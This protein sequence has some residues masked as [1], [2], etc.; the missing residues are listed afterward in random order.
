LNNITTIADHVLLPHQADWMA[1]PAVSRLWRANVDSALSG[2]EDRVSVRQ[3]A[4]LK[5]SYQV[6]P[7]DHVERARF[8]VRAK[9][10]LKAGKM[11][12][13]YWG[14]GE[15]LSEEATTDQASIFLSRSN[16]RIEAGKYIFIQPSVP[17]EYDTWD[18]CLVDRVSGAQIDLADGL[19]HD[20]AAG[21]RVW[22]ILFGKPIT[23]Q[24]EVR[25][26][27]RAIYQ[28][29]I[30]FDGRQINAMTYD[31]FESYDLGEIIDPLDGGTGWDGP[32]LMG[33]AA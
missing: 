31:N 8:D 15:Q 1:T 6:H 4:W 3:S 20:Y 30:Q 33:E 18:L 11:A 28:V 17:A 26:S 21:T 7:Y 27:S 24:F 2:E 14:R 5:L 19:T 29:S 13:P 16:H 9:A 23:D 10:A 12:V 32:W 25:N 22:P